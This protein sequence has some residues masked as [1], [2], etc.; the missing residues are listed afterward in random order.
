MRVSRR[1]S[2]PTRLSVT[3]RD[4]ARAA[5]VSTTTVSH[6]INQTRPVAPETRA[7]VLSAIRELKYYKNSSAR[8]LVRGHSDAFGL[9]ISDIENPFYPELIKS[10][11]RSCHA[12]HVELILGMTNFE[13]DG[14][15]SAV[16]RMIEDKV[17]GVAI[18]TTEFDPKQ[19]N[20]L[21]ERNI[22]VVR[23]SDA[24]VRSSQSNVFIDY[25]NGVREALDHLVELGHRRVSIVHRP[26][27]VLSAKSYRDLLVEAVRQHGMELVSCI[28]AEGRPAGGVGAVQ[29][30]LSGK[31]RP[32]A[33]LCGNDLIA[34]GAAGEA[35]RRGWRV[36]EELSVLGSD[37]IALAAYGH[38]RLSTVRVHRDELGVQAYAI[39]QE[40]LQNPGKGGVSREVSTEFVQRDS[41]GP[42]QDP[43]PD[44]RQNCATSVKNA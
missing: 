14:A 20:R 40:L 6:V 30:I 38:P 1:T 28:E 34:I 7:S 23:L 18:M 11:E 8:L 22:P 9:I 32:T 35:L 15:E 12:E 31:I 29:Q 17:R 33:I 13:R 42:M 43:V 3:I 5:G 4:V 37:D 24:R 26:P 27:R 10:F 16:R 39:L 41:T 44:N 21:I 19:V 25:S 2:A 36:P